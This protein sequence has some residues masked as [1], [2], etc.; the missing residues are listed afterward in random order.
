MDIDTIFPSLS[1]GESVL[2]KKYRHS[3]CCSSVETI[4]ILTKYRLLIRWKESFCLCLHQSSY[5]SIDLNSISRIDETRPSRYYF[6][7]CLISMIISFILIICGIV[8]G[9]IL[10]VALI[11][12]GVIFLVKAAFWALWF[13]FFLKNKYV[14]IIGGCGRITLK[15]EKSIA[16]E[17]EAKLNEL[18]Y[19]TKMQ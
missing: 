12:I 17:F 10:R 2:G 8:A 11:I 13:Y 19:M 15:F 18:V 6:I 16:R 14:T 9:S 7:Y 3:E 4:C 1:C 5:S